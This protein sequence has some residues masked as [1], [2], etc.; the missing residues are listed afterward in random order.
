MISHAEIYPGRKEPHLRSIAKK[1]NVALRD[2]IFFDDL[3]HNIHD[4]EKLG[5]T[6]VQVPNGMDLDRL[7][8][9]LR[10]LVDKSRGSILLNSWLKGS[11]TKKHALKHSGRGADAGS[12][13]VM[14]SSHHAQTE[15]Q[16]ASLRESRER[17]RA[18][19]WEGTLDVEEE[20]NGARS[21]GVDSTLTS[22][23]ETDSDRNR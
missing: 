3:P 5:C 22:L 1:M 21:F 8:L 15:S 16:L 4:A 9:G 13:G 11:S 7:Q 14:P 2:M 6:A 23:K 12:S 20:K 19:E 17:K 10:K 18:R